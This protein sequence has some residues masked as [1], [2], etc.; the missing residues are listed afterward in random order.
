MIDPKYKVGD[1]VAFSMRCQPGLPPFRIE[2]VD[3]D[4]FGVRYQLE[5]RDAWWTEGCFM[6]YSEWKK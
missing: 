3:V 4:L 6:P 2:K 1:E 5:F